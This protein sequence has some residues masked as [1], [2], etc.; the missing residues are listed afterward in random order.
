MYPFIIKISEHDPELLNVYKRL[1]QDKITHIPN[2]KISNKITWQLK[3]IRPDIF[4]GHDCRYKE[5]Y[6]ALKPNL[7]FTMTPKNEKKTV[8][9]LIFKK[10]F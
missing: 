2:R 1:H 9:E 6:I 8:F 4:M 5:S 7:S 10:L 3:P